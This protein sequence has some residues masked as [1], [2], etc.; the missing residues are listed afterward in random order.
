MRVINIL[1]PYS[2]FEVSFYDTSGVV[3]GISVSGKYAY[4]ANS[5][6]G[7]LILNIANPYFPF[8]VGKYD[9]PPPGFAHGVAISGAYAYIAAWNLGLRVIDISNLSNPREVVYYN[10]TGFSHRVTLLGVNAYVADGSGGIRIFDISR[11][12]SPVEVGYYSKPGWTW[13]VTFFGNFFLTANDSSG[14]F[15]LEFLGKR[16][17]QG[18]VKIFLEQ[19]SP[20]PFFSNTQIKYAYGIKDQIILEIYDIIG[21][22]VKTLVNEEQNA[23]YHQIEWNG[24]DNS[25]QRVPSGIYFY[26][27]QVGESYETR[28]MTLLR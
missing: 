9:M 11:P 19:N 8:Q 20:N 13:D 7:L 21:R 25:D 24:L 27:L 23:G 18:G 17:S 3:Y 26:R 15:I 14:I 22:H 5:G 28:K 6:Q 1:N 2:P 4:L 16:G 10:T 12:S